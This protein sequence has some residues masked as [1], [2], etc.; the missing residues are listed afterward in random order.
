MRE[1]E[2]GPEYGYLWTGPGVA[3]EWVQAL[4]LQKIDCTVFPF[5][6]C[7]FSSFVSSLC[8]T[9]ENKPILRYIPS[10]VPSALLVLLLSQLYY[11]VAIIVMFS[12][13]PCLPNVPLPLEQQFPNM[14]Q[15][16]LHGQC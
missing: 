6:P 2:A 13:F 10:K 4:Q 15:S 14:G 5:D 9:L 16:E 11:D 1:G 12:P 7:L 3:Q 8:H